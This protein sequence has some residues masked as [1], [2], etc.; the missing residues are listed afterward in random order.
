M[1]INKTNNSIGMILEIEH[2]KRLNQNIATIII[3][4]G[5]LH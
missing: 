3:W 5:C 1:D 2:D 4:F